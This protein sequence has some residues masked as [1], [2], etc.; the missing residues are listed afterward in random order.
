M[1][2]RKFFAGLLMA[3]AVFTGCEEEEQLGI[4]DVTLGADQL[5]FTQ[6]AGS[7]EMKFTATREWKAEYDADWV[8]VT[9]EGGQGSNAE[10]TMTVTVTENTGANRSAKVKVTIG[11]V[12]KSF[13]VSQAGPDGETDGVESL[14]VKAFIEKADT[15]NYYRL[16]GKV[17]GFN[18]QW[19]SFDITDETGKIYVY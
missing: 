18:A 19:C 16:T 11:M 13:T 12:E 4:P 9:P 14:T 2:I 3:A 1:K 8:A 15:E 10:Q 6:E 5:E 7:Q 17:S